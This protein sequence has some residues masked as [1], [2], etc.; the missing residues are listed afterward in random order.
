MLLAKKD[1][2]R[3]ILD[4]EHNDFLLADASKVE[5]L[6]ELCANVCMMA[7][8]Q[9]ANCD[10]DKGPIYDFDF[11][12]EQMESE[13]SETFKQNKLLNDRLLESTLTYDIVKCVMIH[14]KTRDDT[15]QQSSWV[16]LLSQDDGEYEF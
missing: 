6:E 4:E 2:T 16:F 10:S 14:S 8:I 11:V 15:L 7:R 13:L 9:Q 5:E 3:I 12:S 1:K